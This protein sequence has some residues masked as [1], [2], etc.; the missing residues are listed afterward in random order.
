MINF[1]TVTAMASSYRTIDEVEKLLAS[2]GVNNCYN[3]DSKSFQITSNERAS[4]SSILTNTS[5]IDVISVLKYKYRCKEKIIVK[6]TECDTPF[7][8]KILNNLQVCLIETNLGYFVI[9]PDYLD[10][11][12]IIYN[13]WD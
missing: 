3:N 9:T 11:L 10:N 13:R 6:Y 12:N 7:K 4:I 1:L 5:V 8:S 2:W